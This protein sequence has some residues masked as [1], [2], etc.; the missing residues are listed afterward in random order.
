M[1]S[2]IVWGIATIMT[3]YVTVGV[4][5]PKL[6]N[7][8]HK[9]KESS[10][11]EN[12]ENARVTTDTSFSRKYLF[13]ILLCIFAACVCG[14]RV[15]ADVSSM[16]VNLKI[17]LGYCVLCGIVI[18]DLEYMTIPNCYVGILFIGRVCALIV[19]AIM[20]PEIVFIRLISSVIVCVLCFL[21][22]FIVAKIAKG[23]LG[24]GDIKLFCGL[25]FLCGFYITIYTLVFACFVCGLVSIFLLLFKIKS[26]KDA[27]PMGPFILI[28]YIVTILLAVY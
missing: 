17:C 4:Y 20:E 22:L 27:V 25:A 2:S 15:E 16:L 19:E 3:L 21:I 24:E 9:N 11:T 13:V 5:M 14:F 6:R 26:L 28:G 10:W 12:C 23:G 1:F 7:R 18:T 8:I